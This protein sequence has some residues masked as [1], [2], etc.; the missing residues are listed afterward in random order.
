MTEVEA[1]LLWPLNANSQL[2]EKD[3]DT[4]KDG[5]QEKGATENEMIGWHCQLNG[6]EFDQT[7]GDREGQGSLVRSSSWGHKELDMT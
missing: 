7:L 2:I 1:P 3:P 6:N 5:G 4:G